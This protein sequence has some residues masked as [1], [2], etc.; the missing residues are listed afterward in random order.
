MRGGP[1]NGRSGSRPAG[2]IAHFKSCTEIAA[3]IVAQ[4]TGLARRV[5][6]MIF[7]RLSGARVNAVTLAVIIV[8]CTGYR[9]D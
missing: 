4:S 1:P 3:T 9:T 2:F 8:P 7:R 6:F 5:P